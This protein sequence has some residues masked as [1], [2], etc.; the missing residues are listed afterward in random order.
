MSKV[1]SLSVK[2]LKHKIGELTAGQTHKCEK[3]DNETG[4]VTEYFVVGSSH[5][6]SKYYKDL[7]T[8]LKYKG[9]K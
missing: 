2:E 9:T 3:N 1:K 8:C 7:V 4:K 5:E 6:N